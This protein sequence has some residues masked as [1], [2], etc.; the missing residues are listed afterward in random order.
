MKEA[1]GVIYEDDYA[2][3]S[4]VGE[5]EEEPYYQ[6]EAMEEETEA[7]PPQAAGGLDLR[8]TKHAEQPSRL[9]S[10]QK[11]A[12][13]SAA[14]PVHTNEGTV[15]KW[16]RQRQDQLGEDQPMAKPGKRAKGKE[17]LSPAAEAKLSKPPPK[18][19]AKQA[20][21]EAHVS[22]TQKLL[23]VSRAKSAGYQERAARIKVKTFAEIMAEKKGKA[24]PVPVAAPVVTVAPEP[25]AYTAAEWGAEEEGGGGGEGGGEEVLEEYN[26]DDSGSYT[27]ALLSRDIDAEL[28][29]LNE[30][31]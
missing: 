5:E 24:V 20:K 1:K 2:S 3:A 23:A 25:E 12:K 8:A 27:E 15:T 7:P 6:D 21:K 31:L 30:G 17:K 22:E 4:Y 19:A 11:D 14:A 29:A 18:Q 16:K 9:G 13:P 26:E 10:K 28:A